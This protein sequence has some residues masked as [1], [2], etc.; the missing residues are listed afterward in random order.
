MISGCQY[1]PDLEDLFPKA[2]INTLTHDSLVRSYRLYYD[3][4]VDLPGWHPARQPRCK[5]QPVLCR[6]RFNASKQRRIMYI[7]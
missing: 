7:M 6:I 5:H 2:G 1:E 3:D 4:A